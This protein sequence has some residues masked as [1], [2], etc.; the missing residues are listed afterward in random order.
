MADLVAVLE[1]PADLW[2]AQNLS[3]ALAKQRALAL[4]E[5]PESYNIIVPDDAENAYA[6][7]GGG[8]GWGGDDEGDDW[9][10][11]DGWGD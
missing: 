5:D 11:D 2:P 8:G 10:D 4:L 3:N 6:P 9:G 1:A 7:A